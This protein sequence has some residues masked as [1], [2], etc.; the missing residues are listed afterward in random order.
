MNC[1]SPIMI[2]FIEGSLFS[3]NEGYSLA[4]CISMDTKRGMFRGI[5]VDFLEF[6]PE[7]QQLR[8]FSVPRTGLAIPIRIGNRFIYNLV[9]KSCYWDK[10]KVCDLQFSLESML[11]HAIENKVSNIAIPLLGS[12]CD[13]LDFVR[14]VMPLIDHVFGTSP[15]SVHIYYL[16]KDSVMIKRRY[17]ICTYYYMDVLKVIWCAETITIHWEELLGSSATVIF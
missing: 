2:Q 3:T 5:A 6:F 10:P 1:R 9:T 7:L 12:G 15:V 8:L 13:K 17:N 14:Q 4:H 11:I 16:K